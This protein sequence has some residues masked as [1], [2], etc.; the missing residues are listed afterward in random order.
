MSERK[1][2]SNCEVREPECCLGLS[3]VAIKTFE[4]SSYVVTLRDMFLWPP[5]PVSSLVSP[6]LEDP[7]CLWLPFEL[8]DRKH[9]IRRLLSHSASW[10][11]LILM[12]MQQ[13]AKTRLATRPLRIAVTVGMRW[14]CRL[15]VEDPRLATHRRKMM[16]SC[17]AL[18][19]PSPSN[20]A[21][22]SY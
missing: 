11:Y 17:L 1:V 6:I 3:L 22:E 10:K 13:P 14:A 16:N 2:K 5:S 12:C 18:E 7:D 20:Q 19:I 9:F 8:S 15:G 21:C 4:N